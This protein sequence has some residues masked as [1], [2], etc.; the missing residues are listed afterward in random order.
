VLQK[1][2]IKESRFTQIEGVADSA[3]YNPND[4]K[5]PRNRRVS[6]TIKNQE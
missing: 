3:P 6:I 1:S 5:D 4:P 2:G